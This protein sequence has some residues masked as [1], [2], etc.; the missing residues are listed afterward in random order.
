LKLATFSHLFSEELQ[1]QKNSS[2]K[3]NQQELPSNDKEE[4]EF[5]DQ[6]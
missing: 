4:K 1:S 2:E 3:H 6:E 5:I